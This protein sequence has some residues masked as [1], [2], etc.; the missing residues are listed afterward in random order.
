V[1]KFLQIERGHCRQSPGFEILDSKAPLNSLRHCCSDCPPPRSPT[2]EH[3]WTTMDPP[4]D[5]DNTPSSTP[6]TIHQ[7]L[8]S[9]D[10]WQ[11]LG[12]I[13][14][15]RINVSM[16]TPTPAATP[17]LARPTP[18]N[19]LSEYDLDLYA[20]AVAPHGGMIA[21]VPKPRKS[22]SPLRNGT[23]NNND[24]HLMIFSGSGVALGRGPFPAKAT[25]PNH[26][27]GCVFWTES[28]TLCCV[29]TDG[30]L[31]TYNVHGVGPSVTRILDEYSGNIVTM[32]RCVR[33]LPV[34]EPED[35]QTAASRPVFY[36][37]DESFQSS[38]SQ[39]S[40]DHGYTGVILLTQ[41][42]RLIHV[43]DVAMGVTEEDDNMYDLGSGDVEQ[44]QAG[45]SRRILEMC[46]IPSTHTNSGSIE[47][48]VSTSNNTLLRI[49]KLGMV[50]HAL[51]EQLTDAGP[52][53]KIALAPNGRFLACYT[54]GGQ[55]KVFNTQNLSKSLLDFDTKSGEDP[56]QVVWAGI[57]AVVLRWRQLLLAVGPY[58]H[59]IRYS[60]DLPLRI[61]QEC[62]SCRVITNVTSEIIQRV[63]EVT[64]K[65]FEMGSTEP[66]A[67]LFAAN[68]AF[69]N[70][71]AKADEDIRSI[72][73]SHQLDEA[74]MDLLD[75]ARYEF[76]VHN[77][78]RGQ[79]KLLQAVSYGSGFYE[80]SS[81]GG[82][83]GGGGA[84]NGLGRE[85]NEQK[86]EQDGVGKKSSSIFSSTSS[87]NASAV[88]P[89]QML[90][91]VCRQL[92]VLNSL[93]ATG[94]PM[95]YGMFQAMT[96]HRVVDRLITL[97][98]HAH[99]VR[100]CTYLRLDPRPVLVHWACAKVQSE[101]VLNDIQLHRVF[102]RKLGPYKNISYRKIAKTAAK[103][104]RSKLAEL[105]LDAEPIARIKVSTLCDLGQLDQALEKAVKC[106]DSNLIYSMIFAVQKDIIGRGKKTIKKTVAEVQCLSVYTYPFVVVV[107]C[108][109]L[110]LLCQIQNQQVE[111]MK[112]GFL[113]YFNTEKQVHCC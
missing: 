75:A 5:F 36:S 1:V 45:G 51:Q 69:H 25:L 82:G 108:C 110:L 91:Y 40:P 113:L 104:G 66:S 3:R 49:D 30:A 19:A 15:R 31:L 16:A 35:D 74:M 14:L 86:Q 98:R 89:S 81:G 34:L 76:S 46:V 57:D 29:L 87:S 32:V 21:L 38:E 59:W 71:E 2:A 65:T 77:V 24:S 20:V 12:K 85:Q 39:L 79:K 99:A 72:V 97:H 6:T 23:A 10:G 107:C 18:I 103:V 109:L 67:L 56:L 52:I 106:R 68:Q 102:L 13:Q 47:V 88:S 60:Y 53:M 7:S 105:L 96:A 55:L 70:Q 100:V 17:P 90:N 48:L 27:E 64:V 93:R 9:D 83:G 44:L 43:E 41:T 80:D 61:A 22:S 92:R 78:K 42:G 101:R 63:P 50:D 62:D 73:S 111:K 54:S 58:G 94:L 26:D 84:S 4:P 112:N 8:S 11:A 28:D 95:T 33:N 37:N